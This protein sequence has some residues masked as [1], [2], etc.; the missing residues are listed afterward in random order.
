M[1][2]EDVKDEREEEKNK[3]E[4][5]IE[6]EKDNKKKED[7]FE[8]EEETSTS[9]RVKPGRAVSEGPGH[10]QIVPHPTTRTS[11]LPDRIARKNDDNRLRKAKIHAARLRSAK[12]LQREKE[13]L[14]ASLVRVHSAKLARREAV[15]T[16]LNQ[17]VKQNFG[18][19]SE[20]LSPTEK[21]REDKKAVE[22]V[23]R[24]GVKNFIDDEDAALRDARYRI[25]RTI[26]AYDDAKETGNNFPLTGSMKVAIN[27]T[28]LRRGSILP[29]KEKQKPSSLCKSCSLL[30]RERNMDSLEHERA[31]RQRIQR[32]GKYT[33]VSDGTLEHLALLAGSMIFLLHL[34]VK[35]VVKL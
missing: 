3:T 31:L 23:N 13:D 11:S 17:Q 24:G 22:L 6:E 8:E 28:S 26:E 14:A 5:E 10:R 16:H 4:K 32:A 9:R 7:E 35:F 19:Y 12:T 30:R 25:K 29:F 2:P 27:S 21:K 15:D 18:V 33:D 34:M 1:N 20:P